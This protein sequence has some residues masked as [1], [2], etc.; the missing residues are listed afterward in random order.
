MRL[1]T[2]T[3]TTMKKPT[4]NTS[5]TPLKS[6]G[7]WTWLGARG[8]RY[9]YLLDFAAL[10]ATMLIVMVGRF[11][12]TW[13]D[14]TRQQHLFGML[15]ATCLHIVVYYF[16]GMYERPL[17]LG[18]RMWLSHVAGVTVIA[19]LV[20]ALIIL[21]TGRYPIPRANL[22]FV[23]VIASILVAGNRHLSRALRSRRFGPPR[24]LLVGSPD[25]T[26]LAASHLKESDK[27]AVVAGQIS[28]PERLLEAASGMDATDILLVSETSLDHIYPEPLRSL[29]QRKTGVYLRITAKSALMGLR[30]VRE[31]GGM[32][33]VALRSNSLRPSQLRFKRLV[34]LGILF[35]VSPII[36]IGTGLVAIYVRIRAGKNIL[37]WQTRTGFDGQPFSMVKFRTMGPDAEADGKAVKAGTNDPRIVKGCEWLRTTRADEL[38]QFWNVLRGQMSIVGPRPERPE[39]SAQYEEL[40]PGYSRRN[41]VPPG[42]TGLAQVRGRYHTDPGYKL[43]HDIQYLVSW[44][45]LLDLQI[46]LRTVAVVLRRKQ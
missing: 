28:S 37:Y 21:P 22:P 32:P 31:V 12:S 4:S 15:A 40:I 25:D 43:G 33:Y 30:S 18:R 1:M 2:S 5:A 36:L 10:F 26:E 34:E 6:S 44:S 42:I 3:V 9:L 19:L 14:A 17:R 20:S 24:V 41:E 23:A 46:M 29:E 27:Q 35:V 38:P 39:L 13:P 45:P 11:G 16:A 7:P 8:F